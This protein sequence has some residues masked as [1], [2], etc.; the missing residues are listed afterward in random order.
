VDHTNGEPG[1]RAAGGIDQTSIDQASTGSDDESTLGV[2]GGIVRG[3]AA[4]A[5]YT[6]TNKVRDAL[7]GI[8]ERTGVFAFARE[9]PLTTLGAAF[10]TGLLLAFLTEPKEGNRHVERLRR[11]L[12]A[13]IIS[14]VVAAVASTTPAITGPGGMIDGLGDWLEGD[15]EEEDLALTDDYDDEPEY[16]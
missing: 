2:L 14:G 4:D 1:T 12:K 5:L 11:R 16:E 15:D 8:D 9:R 10:G 7:K 3:A 13:A 6:S